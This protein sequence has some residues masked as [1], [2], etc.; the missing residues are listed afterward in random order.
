[1]PTGYDGHTG[2]A[3]VGDIAFGFYDWLT[4]GGHL[5]A[6]G[7][8]NRMACVRL[9][10]GMYQSGIIYLAKEKAKI[11]RGSQIQG[12]IFA[13]ADHVALGFSARLGYS[14]VQKNRDTITPCNS[15]FS[16]SIA[17]SEGSRLSWKM[18]T[19]HAAAEYDFSR[20][21][22]IVGPRIAV[23]YDAQIA[24]KRIFKMNMTGAAFGIDCILKF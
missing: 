23:F 9:K 18:H 6:V 4:I 22:W 12:G 17:S 1:M 3:F 5:R 16:S 2:I 11:H 7:F 21:H 20:K 13:E 19:I 14:F 8:F 15:L 10:T 24:G